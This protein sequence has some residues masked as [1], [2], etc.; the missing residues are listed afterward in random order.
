[1]KKIISIGDTHGK[2]TWKKIVAKEEFDKIIFIGDF[3]DSF[4]I[5]GDVQIENFKD[6][7]QYKKDNMDKV[8]LLIGNHD[9]HYLDVGEQYSG[10]QKGYQY[11]INSLLK[12]NLNLM[13]MCFL[14]ELYLFTH[15]GVTKT[16]CENN[17]IDHHLNIEDSINDLFKFKPFAFRFTP[18]EA[19]SE[20]GD[21]ICQTPIWVRP[22]SLREDII[23]NFIQ[24]VGH[25][26]QEEI[27]ITE[28]VILIDVL[29]SINEYLKIEGPEVNVLN[30]T[31]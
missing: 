23:P 2:D 13:Q 1:M 15:A 9:Y 16:W 30:L 21:E 7:I 19:Y 6:I 25:T 11:V 28:D 24:I 14:H 20:Y 18:G 29:D 10:Y 27:T 8:V 26:R 31:Q 17:K 3:F 12:E 22:A 5:K 4:D